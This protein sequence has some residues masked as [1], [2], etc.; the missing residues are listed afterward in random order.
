MIRADRPLS[1]VKGSHR[2]FRLVLAALAAALAVGCA[3]SSEVMS[4]SFGRLPDG[5]LDVFR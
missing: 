2:S 3:E 4:K 1:R 5:L